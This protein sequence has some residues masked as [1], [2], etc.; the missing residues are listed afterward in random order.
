MRDFG[1]KGCS[2]YSS[3]LGLEEIGFWWGWNW[4]VKP[5]RRARVERNMMR[6]RGFIAG[7]RILN[8]MNQLISLPKINIG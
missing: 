1:L 6:G 3:I 4:R 5:W 7:E 2:L 8:R